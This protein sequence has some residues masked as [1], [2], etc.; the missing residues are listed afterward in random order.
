MS[1]FALLLRQAE[2][3]HFGYYW[4]WNSYLEPKVLICS[5]KE[6]DTTEQANS[7]S[8]IEVINDVY[9]ELYVYTVNTQCNTY[10]RNPA[11]RSHCFPQ[12]WL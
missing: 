12:A 2:Y 4:I 7:I 10:C 5:P 3:T 1:S 9:N 11:N 8:A 6:S